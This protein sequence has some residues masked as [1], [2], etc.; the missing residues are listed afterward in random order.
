MNLGKYCYYYFFI[1]WNLKNRFKTAGLLCNR[2][3]PYWQSSHR[4]WLVGNVSFTQKSISGFIRANTGSHLKDENSTWRYQ[5]ESS[6]KIGVAN[7][8]RFDKYIHRYLFLTRHNPA[9]LWN[10]VCIVYPRL[11]AMTG[12]RINLRESLV[13]RVISICF[14]EHRI[15][16]FHMSR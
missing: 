6:N 12:L 3:Q 8:C 2:S 10:D 14:Y 7:S 16:P 15:S 9:Y 4:G 13:M 1:F 11:N 5:V